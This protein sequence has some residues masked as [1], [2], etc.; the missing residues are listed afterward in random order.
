[1]PLTPMKILSIQYLVLKTDKL[2]FSKLITPPKS[3]LLEEYIERYYLWKT[4]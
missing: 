3:E 2:K 1:M 4:T